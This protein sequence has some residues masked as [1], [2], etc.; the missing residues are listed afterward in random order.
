MINDDKETLP[1]A[2]LIISHCG[3]LYSN[4]LSQTLV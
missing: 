3:A 2:T 4:S 1:T